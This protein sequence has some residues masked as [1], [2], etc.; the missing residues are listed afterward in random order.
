MIFFLLKSSATK[1]EELNCHMPPNEMMLSKSVF[2]FVKSVGTLRA[3]V[4]VAVKIPCFTATS[5]LG[6]TMIC[7][8]K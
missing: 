2:G 7:G 1:S 8:K 6:K 3:K 5:G 4:F